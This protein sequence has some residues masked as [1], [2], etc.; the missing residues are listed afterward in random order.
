MDRQSQGHTF[1]N[2]KFLKIPCFDHPN[3]YITN[4]CCLLECLKP[5][6]PDCID[7]H[8]KYHKQL[9][10]YPLIDSLK[11]VRV[12]CGRKVK[13]AILSL[14]KELENLE[15]RDLA[16]PKEIEEESLEHL[17]RCREKVLAMVNNFFDN[18]EMQHN[19]LA[20]EI[21][22]RIDANSIFEKVRNFINDL[23]Y[24]QANLDSNN[25]I[26]V[27]KKICSMDL[28]AFVDKHKNEISSLLNSN[29]TAQ[30]IVDINERGLS[31]METSLASS[32]N[33]NKRTMKNLSNSALID[34]Y[35]PSNQ[36]QTHL[37]SKPQNFDYFE[38]KNSR[39][40]QFGNTSYNLQTSPVAKAQDSFIRQSPSHKAQ[41]EFVSMKV[42]LPDFFIP[43][44]P[45]K[46]LHFFPNSDKVLYL[47]NLEK[48]H[49]NSYFYS[50]QMG[51]VK[52]F[53]EEIQ[54]DIP[55]TIPR[56]HKSVETPRGDIIIFGGSSNE[57]NGKKVGTT[58]VFDA[59]KRTLK[60]IAEMVNARSSHSACY[61]N[62][63]IYAVGGF[64][65]G[66]V[67]TT[68]CERFNISSNQ[69]KVIAPM[70]YNSVAASLCGFNNKFILKFGGLIDGVVLN[71]YIEK[72]DISHD[73]WTTLDIKFDHHDSSR[74]HLKEFKLLSTSASSQINENE[75]LVFG[76]YQEDNDASTLTF[77]CAFDEDNQEFQISK[78]NYRPLPT[79]EGFWNN[80]PVIH[81]GCLY[82]LQNIANQSNDDCLEYERRI[83]IYN[84]N[85][86][87]A[88]G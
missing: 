6:C 40:A 48:F 38:D 3:E 23:E 22:N 16:N 81:Q 79:G 53:F 8:T 60:P 27:M 35:Y 70:N 58:F 56:F 75:I 32:F 39:Q 12:N 61:M 17:R 7:A 83:L 55:F 29:Q 43:S 34:N 4:F 9:S 47:L 73:I 1:S 19:R 15:L 84:G 46:H 21:T 24:L 65:N 25:A 76:G 88:F 5:L 13:A 54:L 41:S 78:V 26:N 57:V 68:M 45:N 44:C 72:Y 69:W 80:N 42:N 30:I 11:S 18:L 50:R 74:T 28:K 20:S 63:Y 33:L 59:A 36:H 49:E 67:Y 86:W 52:S 82:S 85:E 31:E 64:L 77:V 51:E 2:D 37:E 62:G 87:K 14:T 71:S 66:Q 10:T